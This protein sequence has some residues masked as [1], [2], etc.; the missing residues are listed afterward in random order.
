MS[1][2]DGMKLHP[3]VFAS[4]KEKVTSKI[5][6]E[7]EAICLELSTAFSSFDGKEG[8]IRIWYAGRGEKIPILIEL[9]LPVGDIKFELESVE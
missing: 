8:K 6:G 5:Y 9:E 2:F 3:M 7:V 1:I 4:R